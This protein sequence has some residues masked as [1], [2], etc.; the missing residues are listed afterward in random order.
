M[1]QH[2]LLYIRC[3]GQNHQRM[4]A[5]SQPT[6]LMDYLKAS[7]D[8]QEVY[9]RHLALL[10][11]DCGENVLLLPLRIYYIQ[12]TKPLYMK[13]FEVHYN[14]RVNKIDRIVLLKKNLTLWQTMSK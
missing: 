3:L 14:I 5:I 2:H 9:T 6:N 8:M 12:S 10:V 7:D 1:H 4:L 13:Q 11:C